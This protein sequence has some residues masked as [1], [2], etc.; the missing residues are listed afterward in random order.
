M[1][2]RI[3][4]PKK[5]ASVP[6]GQPWSGSADEKTLFGTFDPK[7]GRVSKTARCAFTARE[8]P[9]SRTLARPRSVGEA[10]V[11]MATSTKA[12]TASLQAR[13]RM[14]QDLIEQDAPLDE[15]LTLLC[16]IVEAEAPGLVRAAI[17][18]VDP[19]QRCL[20]TGAAPGLPDRYNRAVDGI[21]IDPD[22]GTCAAAAATGQ[23]VVTPDIAADP[24]W[25]GLAHLPLDL[26]LC[27]AWS[28]PI[29]GDAGEVLGTFGTYFTERRLPTPE[30]RALV[31]VLARTAADA[32]TRDRIRNALGVLVAGAG[33]TAS[34]ESS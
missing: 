2:V 3:A 23:V 27:A 21:G 10:P 31:E 14:A 19:E 12:V 15:T 20:R 13:Q 24:A 6:L 32:I 7:A 9:P 17:L 18:L 29:L 22:V 5:V 34:M 33:A 4:D 11:A 25:K 30:E 1:S 26:G 28:M 16:H 8:R